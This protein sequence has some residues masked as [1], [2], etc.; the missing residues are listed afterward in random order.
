MPFEDEN[1]ID[2]VRSGKSKETSDPLDPSQEVLAAI[3]RRGDTLMRR[4]VLVHCA[5]A[6]VLAGFYD[7]WFLTLTVSIAAVGMFLSSSYLLPG[8]F[9]TRCIAGVTLQAFV[10]LHIYQLH[11]MPEMHFFF[12][13]ASTMLIVYQDWRCM[14]PGTLLIIGQHILFAALT[15]SG[16][17]MFFF[18]EAYISFTKLLF[19]FGIA[20][21]QVAV[22]GIWAAQL[23]SWTL[24]GVSQQEL[25]RRDVTR[26]QEAEEALAARNFELAVARDEALAST[27]SKSQFL[28]NMSHE[29]R[30]PM[31]GVIG[32][33]GILLDTP[34]SPEQQ[35]IASTIRTSADALLTIINDLLD[36]SKIEAGRM[37]TEIADFNLREVLESAAEVIAHPANEKG[38]ELVCVYPPSVPELLRGDSGRIRQVMINLLGN[39]VKF[40]E[41]GEIVLEVASILDEEG[42]ARIRVS[43]T[44]TGIG[45]HPD[46]L[47]LIFDS[48]TQADGTTTRRF[49]GTGLGLTISR[50]LVEL[51]G[52]VIG[53]ESCEGVGSTFWAEIPFGKQLSIEVRSEVA[54]AALDGAS[55]LVVAESP[56]IRK[57]LKMNLDAWNCEAGELESIEQALF[58]LNSAGSVPPKVL[59]VDSAVLELTDDS[60]IRTLRACVKQSGCRV[61]HLVNSAERQIG[62]SRTH[63]EAGF[64][65]AKPIRRS[66]LHEVLS[67]A[68]GN[69][70]KRVGRKSVSSEGI[71]GMGSR[72]RVLVAEDSSVNQKVAKALLAKL[73]CEADAVDNGQEALDALETRPYDVVLMDCHMPVLDG[74]ESAR[75]IRQRESTSIYSRHIPIIALTASAMP[76]DR[77]RCLE[78]GMDDYIT[79]PIN[80]DVLREVL[81][82]WSSVVQRKGGNSEALSDLKRAA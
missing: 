42:T 60:Y 80:P 21:A 2:N 10:A 48:F 39:A 11:G 61:I 4:F 55:V 18:P 27:K 75:A 47:S 53:V 46:R 3:Y 49:G 34:L 58:V 62:A 68:L 29:I 56:S 73:G 14:W 64:S 25:L 45:I 31:N 40:T 22:C 23:R 16:V 41:R 24:T 57:V 52:G 1:C 35:E 59:V 30:T 71:E 33:T 67:Q 38:L 20:S 78:A 9:I 13:T 19:H 66:A 26:A 5:I 43:V 65:L 36:F 82:R 51:M 72:I 17:Q 50:Q 32:M 79:K 6:V 69:S 15:N 74:Y 8:T 76:G 28:A 81:L 54:E 77:E 44:D 37:E 63:K 12:F 70:A 7:T